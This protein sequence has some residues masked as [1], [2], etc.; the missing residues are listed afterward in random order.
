VR[1]KDVALA[2]GLL[3]HQK[4][5]L[6]ADY[7]VRL[8][9]EADTL[10]AVWDRGPMATRWKGEDPGV[11]I[12]LHVNASPTNP[13]ARGF[14]T[15]FL[16]EARTE[17][18]RR[19]AELENAPM[20]GPVTNPLD[21]DN[22][23]LGLILNELRNLDHSHWSSLLAEM[24]QDELAE[25]HPGP[26]RGVKQGPLAVI[27]NAIMPGVLIEIGF[28]SNPAEEQLLVDAGFQEEV[29]EAVAA[30]VDRFLERYPPGANADAQPTSPDGGRDG[31]RDGDGD[32]DGAGREGRTF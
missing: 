29:A 20:G 4:L 19:L 13:S 10:V 2:I 16:S 12:S 11:F 31:R 5:S 32:S 17:H 24:V 28:V 27:T 14:E 18:E 1:E 21:S 23:E 26:N 7:D 15:F 3:L 25:V 8:T 9:R 6:R 30:A 22:P